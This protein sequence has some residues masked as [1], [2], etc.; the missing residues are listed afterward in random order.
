MIQLI[1]L[2][3]IC[4]WRLLY[5]ISVQRKY[6]AAIICFLAIYA[7]WLFLQ[8]AF[9]LSFRYDWLD[10]GF[11]LLFIFLLNLMLS[12]WIVPLGVYIQVGCQIIAMF[13]MVYFNLALEYHSPMLDSFNNGIKMDKKGD[14]SITARGFI[15]GFTDQGFVVIVNQKKGLLEQGIR[16][17]HGGLHDISDRITSF[18]VT[19]ALDSIHFTFEDGFLLKGTYEYLRLKNL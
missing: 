10:T 13:L 6:H 4:C 19:P 3:T 2:A 8:N 17:T 12:Y 7:I 5:T 14:Y 18:D 1:C 15:T 11:F 9:F 16:Y